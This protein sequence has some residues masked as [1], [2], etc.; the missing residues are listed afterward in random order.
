MNNQDI[1]YLGRQIPTYII[2]YQLSQT[3]WKLLLD[4]LKLI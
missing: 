2:E 1:P 3:E 4:R